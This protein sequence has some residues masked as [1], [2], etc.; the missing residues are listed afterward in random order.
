MH[1]VLLT[2]PT[3]NQVLAYD[4]DNDLWVNKSAVDVGLVGPTGPTGAG[5]DF[6]FIESTPPLP[7]PSTPSFPTPHSDGRV[8][9]ANSPTWIEYVYGQVGAYKVGDYV[10]IGDTITPGS[11][12]FGTVGEITGAGTPEEA[13]T[14]AIQDSSGP[15]FGIGNTTRTLSLAVRS[16][17]GY[18]FPLQP[19]DYLGS[20]APAPMNPYWP[21]FSADETWED[22][23]AY[24]ELQWFG[25]VGDY[26]VGDYVRMYDTTWST[27][28]YYLGYVLEV[29]N[30]GLLEE[31]L[32]LSVTDH[33]GGD[34]VDFPSVGYDTRRVSIESGAGGGGSGGVSQTDGTVTTATPSSAVVRNIT[35]ST[36]S[37]SGGMEGDVWLRYTA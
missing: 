29:N 15:S 12:M 10:R 1:D 36:S 34:E 31:H 4:D 19:V 3:N 21:N 27:G 2:S 30:R 24:N 7:N 8:E 5:Y 28:L 33:A 14:I 20:P 9:W 6:P 23:A 22:V 37:P 17:P 13:M 35:I 16:N 18:S 26:K 11:Y 32:V 25:S